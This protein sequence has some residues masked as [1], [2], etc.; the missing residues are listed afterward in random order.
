MAA[1]KAVVANDHPEQK[2]II[3]M[4]GGGRVVPYAEDDFA[5]AIVTLLHNPDLAKE[6]GIKGREYVLKN[7]TYS[8]ISDSLETLYSSLLN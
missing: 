1:G 7:R 8:T 5:D 3:E 2:E 6:M 4:S